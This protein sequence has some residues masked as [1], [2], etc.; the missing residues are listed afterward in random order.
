MVKSPACFDYEKLQWLNGH[1]IR[2]ADEERIFQLCL[3]YL[4]DAD[5]INADFMREGGRPFERM[6]GTIKN[7]LK[8]ISDVGEQLTYFLGEV[9]S[10]D[11]QALEKYM[12][13]ETIPLLEQEVWILE[14]SFD[15]N[16]MT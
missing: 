16:A 3:E 11:P 7:S 9:H 5:A 12:I 1:Y 4:W 14:D 8:T 2:E 10:Y 6:V 15:F 13:P